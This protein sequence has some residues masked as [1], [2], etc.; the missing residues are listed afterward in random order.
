MIKPNDA[1]RNMAPLSKDRIGSNAITNGAIRLF[2]NENP[3]GM[4]LAAAEAGKI[5][6]AKGSLYPEVDGEELRRAIGG[7]LGIAADQIFLGSGVEDLFR[8][9]CQIY[10]EN[11][12]EIIVPKSSWGEYSRDASIFG[13]SVKEIPLND[14]EVVD[15]PAMASAIKSKTKMIVFCNPNN[16]TGTVITKRLFL[17]MMHRIGEEIL[18]VVDESYIAYIG[19]AD[20]AVGTDYLKEFPNLVVLRSFSNVYGLAGFRIAY[21]VAHR[22]VAR[23]IEKV[24][25]TQ[26]W[27][28]SKYFRRK[29]KRRLIRDWKKPRKIF[30]PD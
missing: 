24:K 2:A 17:Q 30:S 26:L 10:L 4:S 20:T 18:V 19:T 29:R 14:E 7:G 23:E 6:V 28:C 3:L 11:G 12:D 27:D 9:L 13:A 16:P 5:A 25:I 8:M 1:V 15:F 21:G 22:E